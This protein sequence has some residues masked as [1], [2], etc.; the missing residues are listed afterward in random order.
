MPDVVFYSLPLHTMGPIASGDCPPRYFLD[1]YIPLVLSYTPTLYALTESNSPA[2][3]ISDEFL[4]SRS[5]DASASLF[6]G[7]LGETQVVQL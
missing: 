5:G 4:V 6:L 7:T 3:H 1:L 2:L